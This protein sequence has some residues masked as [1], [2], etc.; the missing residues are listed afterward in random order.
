MI[1][2]GIGCWGCVNNCFVI[3]GNGHTNAKTACQWQKL[4]C[5][6]TYNSCKSPMALKK[7]QWDWKHNE[8]VLWT[9]GK[10]SS[11]VLILIVDFSKLW[12]FLKIWVSWLIRWLK[13]FSIS[14]KD[15][16]W[17]KPKQR[18]PNTTRTILKCKF[19]TFPQIAFF[20]ILT[21]YYVSAKKFLWIF[22][23]M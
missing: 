21:L 18:Q 19:F 13:W 15:L 8:M 22:L 16:K 12:K 10:Q 11:K 23:Q 5:R 4:L 14:T 3:H 9:D 6:S 2:C 17:L 20:Y 1:C 7:A